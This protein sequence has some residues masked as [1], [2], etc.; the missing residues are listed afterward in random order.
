[1]RRPKA[2]AAPPGNW[3]VLAAVLG[4]SMV[5]LDGSTVNVSLPALQASLGASVIDV[6]W[7]INGYTLFLAALLMLG[8]SLGDHLGRK[9]TFVVGMVWFTLASVWCGL[10]ANVTQLIVGRALQGVG[11]ALLTPG[12]LA[13]INASFP[14]GQRGGAIGSWS[15]FSAI[16][17]AAGP[18]LGG[19]L[20]DTFSWRW[21]FFIN[22]PLAAA[23]IYVTVRHVRE[24]RDARAGG[25][26]D[27]LGAALVTLGLGGA[28]YALLE[29]SARSW[30]DPV[31]VVTGLGGLALLAAFVLVEARS[32]GPMVPLELFRSRV[33][34]GINVITLLLYANL[35]GLMFFLPMF[36]I[37][38]RG[39]SATAAGAAGL[40]LV[41]L[42]LVASS[43]SGRLYDRVGPRAP[44]GGG[45]LLT[46]AA[47]VMFVTLG[48]AP[49]FLAAVTVP[50]I[51]MGAGMAL[52]VAP[53]TTTVMAAA[54]DELA[55]TA[56]GINNAVSRVAGL[57]AIGVL[58]LVMLATFAAD[59]AT[60][61]P[62][63]DLPQP[64]QEAL[65]AARNDLAGMALP[66]E[67]TPRQAAVARDAVG[68]A[69][70]LG[71]H[72]VL[73][74][75]AGAAVVAALLAATTLPGRRAAAASTVDDQSGRRAPT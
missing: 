50:M 47:L 64:A 70:T 69:F 52:L 53:L 41:L 68:G 73:Y 11:G 30:T 71:F 37:Q 20:I 57:L 31:I 28:V 10:A 66:P 12:S 26:L 38:V 9:R 67:L 32:A 34:S 2:R 25:R 59:L 72:R 24:S 16:A 5:F 40:P 45:A 46:A 8:G 43:W 54:P 44:V 29:A 3:V 51:V 35:A 36:L 21:I 39:F 23:A 48:D 22:V 61:L 62:A 74:G 7:V 60:T 17:A 63:S 6:Q 75:M 42:L 18:I 27:Y 1:M 13:L 19:W 56:S 58:G 49:T 4:S 55:G 33:F 65:L 15:A 14:K